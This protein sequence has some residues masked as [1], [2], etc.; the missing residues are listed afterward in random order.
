MVYIHTY[1][2]TCTKLVSNA[3]SGAGTN[4]GCSCVTVPHTCT[5]I[6]LVSNAHTRIYTH[7]YKPCV[8]RVIWGGDECGLLLCDCVPFCKA[9]ERVVLNFSAAIVTKTFFRI[10]RLCMCVCM[11][12]YIYIYICIHVYVLYLHTYILVYIYIYATI[13][14]VY[15]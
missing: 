13:F 4:A 5:C 3:S 6:N 12:V 14:R 1:I 9:E 2:H 7:M 11:C 15:V 10:A 8:K